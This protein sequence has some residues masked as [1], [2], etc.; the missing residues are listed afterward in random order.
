MSKNQK[1]KKSII[2]GA[3]A[4]SLTLTPLSSFFIFKENHSNKSEKNIL[5]A[6]FEKNKM[7]NYE[8]LANRA[9]KNEKIINW[10]LSTERKVIHN[11]NDDKK[12][13]FN[14]DIECHWSM[15]ED[16]KI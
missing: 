6:N 12:A 4:L 13:L 16:I 3:S 15:R 11:F 8:I 7:N 5:K 10:I 9:R 1:I 2:I 14:L